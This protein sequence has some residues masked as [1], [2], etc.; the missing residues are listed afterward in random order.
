MSTGTRKSLELVGAAILVDGRRLGALAAGLEVDRQHQGDAG[1]RHDGEANEAGPRPRHPHDPSVDNGPEDA[2]YPL[3]RERA[4]EHEW[5]V[6]Q[7]AQVHQHASQSAVSSPC[8]MRGEQSR[9]RKHPS[10]KLV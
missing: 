3:G 9:P 6:S 7:H 1:H 10:P 5:E 4:C 8:R 2:A